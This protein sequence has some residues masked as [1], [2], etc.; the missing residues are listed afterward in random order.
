MLIQLHVFTFLSTHRYLLL[1]FY[2]FFIWQY[3]HRLFW[4]KE[5]S[6]SCFLQEAVW[7]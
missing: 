4:V 7:D 1:A 5:A 6:L 3:I 2:N